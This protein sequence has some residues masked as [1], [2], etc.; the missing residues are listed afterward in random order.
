[1]TTRSDVRLDKIREFLLELQGA[2]S[3]HATAAEWPDFEDWHHEVHEFLSFECSG[4]WPDTTFGTLRFKPKDQGL[5]VAV[6]QLEINS[7]DLAEEHRRTWARA[8][9]KAEDLLGRMLVESVPWKR[10]YGMEPPK[11]ERSG[12]PSGIYAGAGGNIFINFGNI[13]GAQIQQGATNSQQTMIQHETGQA[14]SAILTLVEDVRATI[15]AKPE[16]R[17]TI[18]PVADALEGAA[19]EQTPSMPTIK[20]LLQGLAGLLSGSDHLRAIVERIPALI[21]IVE[22]LGAPR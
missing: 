5:W 18:G 8:S 6:G 2:R 14:L 20:M 22:K 19:R 16:L 4:Q 12:L 9:A 21:A 11:L 13:D 3:K 1:M 7:V 10:P 15:E 17:P